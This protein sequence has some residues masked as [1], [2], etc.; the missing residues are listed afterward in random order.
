MFAKRLQRVDEMVLMVLM[1]MKTHGDEDGGHRAPAPG[2]EEA[3]P[4][5]EAPGGGRRRRQPLGARPPCPIFFLGDG[6]DVD[7]FLAL[8]GCCQ[9]GGIS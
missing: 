9:G 7:E 6:G 1:K 3:V 2:V 8:L 4:R 5:R